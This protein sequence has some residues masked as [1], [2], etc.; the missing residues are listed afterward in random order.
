M[1]DLLEDS[2]WVYSGDLAQATNRLVGVNLGG[3]FYVTGG[4]IPGTDSKK[5]LAWDPEDREWRE[6]G[7]MAFER[8]KHA[9]T[10]AA[11]STIAN[12]CNN[13]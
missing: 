4:S 10:V 8:S 7:G 2:S 9:V 5:I 12:H 13:K 1:F 11:Y 6:E 3:V